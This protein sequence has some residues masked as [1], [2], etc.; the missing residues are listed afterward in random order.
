MSR[1]VVSEK[2]SCDH[3][4]RAMALGIRDAGAG[5]RAGY[6][7]VVRGPGGNRSWKRTH[8]TRNLNF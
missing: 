4:A 3:D 6:G 2:V 5:R 7:V 1:F 8:E